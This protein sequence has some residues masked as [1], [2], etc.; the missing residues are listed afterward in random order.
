MDLMNANSFEN[1]RPEDQVCSAPLCP[2]RYSLQLGRCLG[3][4]LGHIIVG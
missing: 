1:L 4:L 2:V 3:I